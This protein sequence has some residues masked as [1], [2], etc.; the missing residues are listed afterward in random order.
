MHFVTF[1][2]KNFH[3]FGSTFYD[4][5][6]LRKK[7]FVDE[8]NWDIVHDDHVEMDQYDNPLAH[9][10]VVIKDGK[11]VGGT[12]TAPT[13]AKWG[14]ATYM[15]KDVALGKLP[16]I[17]SQIYTDDFDTDQVWECTRLVVSNE[18][19]SMREKLACLSL[20]FDGV[21]KETQPLGARHLIG[22]SQYTFP[23]IFRS[24]GYD[25]RRVS[26]P[27]TCPE[28]GRKYAV[29]MMPTAKGFVETKEAA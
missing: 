4:Y 17:P 19:K 18:L 9:Y 11:I 25:C 23:R 12:R 20:I 8:L 27:Y 13:S 2:F 29:L 10:S 7:Y 21:I 5:L 28:D 6:A 22:L 26:E 1:N 24:F 14:D 16:K 3:K 15:L